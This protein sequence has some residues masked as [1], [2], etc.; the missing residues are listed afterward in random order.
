LAGGISEALITTAAGLS[1]AIPA[2]IFHR[3][4]ERRIDSLV[5]TMEDQAIKLVDAMH[6]DRPA[7]DV[8]GTAKDTTKRSAKGNS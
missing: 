8:Q 7:S 3:Y 2:V 6:G 1:V 4:F 5:I